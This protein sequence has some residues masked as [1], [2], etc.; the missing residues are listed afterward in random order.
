M[1]QVV[2]IIQHPDYNSIDQNND[3][4]IIQLATEA[5]FNNY[6]QPI[7]LWDSNKSELA[8]VIGKE[9]TV[10]GWG[11]TETD[12]VSNVLQ[13]AM[14]PVVP[15]LRCLASNRNFFGYFLSDKNFCAG[16]QNGLLNEKLLKFSG[17]K[18]NI[19]ANF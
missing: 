13:Q 6:V 5:M 14:M 9:G 10:I 19:R 4:A 3:I 16:N 17:E 18:V 12:T 15:S 1:R 11:V 8:E 2:N 7:C